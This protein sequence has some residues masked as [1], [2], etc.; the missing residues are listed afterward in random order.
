MIG[1][2]KSWFRIDSVPDT[3][4]PS[5]KLASLNQ[6]IGYSIP[7]EHEQ[8]FMRALRHRS[9]VDNEKYERYETYERLEFLGD[10]VLDLII[11]EILFDLYPKENEGFLTKLRAKIVRGDTLFQLAKELGLSDFLEVGDRVSG[12][13]LELS[14][15][16]LSDVFEAMVAAVYI[17]GGYEEAFRFVE[18]TL[19]KYLDFEEVVQTID[20]Y[21]SLLMEFS[22]SEKWKLPRYQVV[23]EVGPGHNKTFKVAVFIEGEK[24]GEGSGKSKKK[25]EQK[26]AQKALAALKAK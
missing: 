15:G 23:S 20:N 9:I 3:A 22:Q 2:L 17:S 10:A 1:R 18:D 26:A 14:K 21:K 12:Q 5:Q 16:V 25:A 7:A 4:E 8:L 19:N 13:G 24:M 6:I 11:T